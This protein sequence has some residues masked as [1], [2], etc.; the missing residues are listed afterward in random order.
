MGI[1]PC[2]ILFD[3]LFPAY[4]KLC[5]SVFILLVLFSDFYKI[6]TGVA[7]EDGGNVNCYNHFGK[8]FVTLL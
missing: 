5:L 1:I 6:E 8:Q 7:A 3:S 4:I 2:A